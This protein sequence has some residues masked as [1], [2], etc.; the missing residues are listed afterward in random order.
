[1]RGPWRLTLAA[2]MRM[3]GRAWLQ[4]GVQPD[5]EGCLIGQTAQYDPAGLLG[6]LYW[7]ASYPV[8]QFVFAGMLT[9]IARHARA[10]RQE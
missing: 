2:E 6:L 8:H 9:G 4:F 10:L 3:P 7:Y 5:G 1:M